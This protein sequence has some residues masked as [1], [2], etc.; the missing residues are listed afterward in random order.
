MMPRYVAVRLQ[1]CADAG[2][3]QVYVYREGVYGWRL[4]DS[5]Q[6][7][8]SYQLVS[9]CDGMKQMSPSVDHASGRVT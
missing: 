5:V 9:G 1:V 3:Q 4:D 8:P 2:L 6:P 7:Y